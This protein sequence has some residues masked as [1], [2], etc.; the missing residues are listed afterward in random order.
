MNAFIS[1]SSPDTQ[2]T[3]RF[4]YDV[5]SSSLLSTALSSTPRSGSVQPHLPVESS[6]PA[7]DSHEIQIRNGLVTS[8]WPPAL[9][10]IAIVA[11]SA[12]YYFVALFLFIA[13]FTYYQLAKTRASRVSTMNSVCPH[14]ISLR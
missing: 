2:F 1:S 4:K 14:S 12:E 5:I 9:V 10:S 8:R 6:T 11:L 7:D 3:E 13:A